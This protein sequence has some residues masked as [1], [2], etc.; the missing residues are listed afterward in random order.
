MSKRMMIAAP[1]LA[2]AMLCLAIGVASARR[3]AFSERGFRL[4]YRELTFRESAFGTTIACPVTLE[5]SFH[6]KTLSKVAE[7]L[8]GYLTKASV[9]SASC[10][11]GHARALTETLPWHVR[12]ESFT[13]T[14][15][16]IT[17]ITTDIIG[18]AFL[19]EA[20]GFLSC[21]YTSTAA[22]PAQNI[23]NV[24]NGN[25]NTIN[26]VIAGGTPRP[27]G[28]NCPRGS[29]SGSSSATVQGG[30]SAITVTLVA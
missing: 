3:I 22:E 30:T 23:F 8:V 4:V 7:A 17:S 20:F 12:Y 13:G 21:L 26:N 1:A 5:G 6:S 18:A 28:A 14:L 19:V 2:A 29:L 27:N 25:N 11:G 10:T 9:A 24:I 15:P 16:S